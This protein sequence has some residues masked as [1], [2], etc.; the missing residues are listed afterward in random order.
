M[1]RRIKTSRFPANAKANGIK[2]AV[3]AQSLV[4]A[5]RR[6]GCRIER[7]N[8]F[9]AEARPMR[10]RDIESLSIEGCFRPKGHLY[11]C[12]FACCRALDSVRQCDADQLHRLKKKVKWFT[13]ELNKYFGIR[14]AEAVAEFRVLVNRMTDMDVVSGQ[15]EIRKESKLISMK[16]MDALHRLGVLSAA[17]E[18]ELRHPSGRHPIGTGSPVTPPGGFTAKDRKML[19]EIHQASF[20]NE[21][22]TDAQMADGARHQ[23]ILLG[24]ELYRPRTKYDKGL[25]FGK[26]AKA[27]IEDPQFHSV[28]GAYSPDEE[29][30]LAQAIRREVESRKNESNE[31]YSCYIDRDV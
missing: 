28:P 8:R 24:A 15:S 29:R 6:V 16:G 12:F 1:K 9:I 31:I 10:G 20:L 7:A 13:D 21:I 3:A 22:P 11:K 2:F 25:S 19:R 30:S 14:H 5:L 27:A 17:R 23:Q 4:V 26:A 18:M